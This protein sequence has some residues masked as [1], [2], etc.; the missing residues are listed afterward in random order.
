MTWR[1]ARELEAGTSSALKN[2]KIE[3]IRVFSVKV[4][5]NKKGKS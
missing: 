1:R 2:I 4:L 5:T 3:N